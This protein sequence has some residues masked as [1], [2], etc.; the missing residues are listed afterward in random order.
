MAANLAL[1]EQV[2]AG[3]LEQA[4]VEL[5]SYLRRAEQHLIEVYTA[6]AESDGAHPQ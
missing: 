6:A 3:K 2:R 4:A 5:G 1:S